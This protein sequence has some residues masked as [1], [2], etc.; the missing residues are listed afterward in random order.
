M[1]TVIK[2]NGK[3]T[4]VNL[5]KGTKFDDFPSEINTDKK[6][7]KD[8]VKHWVEHAKGYDK[9][10]IR[11]Y[12]K[13]LDDLSELV[14]KKNKEQKDVKATHRTIK[15]GGVVN[16]IEELKSEADA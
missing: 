9:G 11:G 16:I 8:I 14:L 7:V 10:F 15:I 1:E 2:I 12:N 5:P 13:A 6:R 4:L 3:D